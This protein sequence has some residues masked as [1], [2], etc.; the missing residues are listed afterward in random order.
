MVF[1]VQRPIWKMAVHVQPRQPM[2]AEIALAITAIATSISAV[3]GAF[4][5]RPCAGSRLRP[6]ILTREQALELA[7]AFLA[8]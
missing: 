3:A 5:A 7:K 6:A 1:M 4:L 8:G 2:M